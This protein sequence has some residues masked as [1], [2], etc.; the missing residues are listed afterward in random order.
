MKFIS[1]ILLLIVLVSCNSDIDKT[2]N[3]E[4]KKIIG[5]SIIT[6][7][8]NGQSYEDTGKL[9]KDFFEI[10]NQITNKKSDDIY[11]IY[12]DFESD[13]TGVYTAIVGYEVHSLTNI[14]KGLVGKEIGGGKYQKIIARGE[15][16]NAI[17]KAW[18]EI[19]KKDKEL[20]RR[21]T[22]D[23]EIHGINSQKGN[24]SEVEIFVSIN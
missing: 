21:Y 22:S 9:W 13:Y 23:F 24:D 15:M 12:T 8:E 20:H 10:A 7:N 18:Q 4:T 1:K 3:M 11:A 14:P 6:T 17:M 16:P 19:W 2:E 5:V